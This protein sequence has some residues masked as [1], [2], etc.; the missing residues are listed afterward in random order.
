MEPYNLWKTAIWM[1]PTLNK[2]DRLY[3]FL[4]KLQKGVGEGRR[5]WYVFIDWHLHKFF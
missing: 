5:G 3:E 1:A 2:T 4:L